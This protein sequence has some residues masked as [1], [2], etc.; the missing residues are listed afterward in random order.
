MSSLQIIVLLLWISVVG[1]SPRH[2]Y[3]NLH[4]MMIVFLLLLPM[5]PSLAPLGRPTLMGPIGN[6]L[7]LGGVSV[8]QLVLEIE[9]CTALL[10]CIVLKS[11]TLV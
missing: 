2:Q 9:Y 8:P 4:L 3:Y 6:R 5:E 10:T 1:L 7:V 11:G